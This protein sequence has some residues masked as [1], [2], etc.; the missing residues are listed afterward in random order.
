MDDCDIQL[1]DIRSG[2]N[3]KNDQKDII[4][5]GHLDFN[6]AAKFLKNNY[7]ATGG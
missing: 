3:C 1:T 6:F 4:L 5:K 2:S 7:L